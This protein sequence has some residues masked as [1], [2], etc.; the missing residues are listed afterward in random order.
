MASTQTTEEVKKR[1]ESL[2]ESIKN[3]LYSF[4]M[5]SI[6]TKIGEKYGLH[7][8]QM[9]TLNAETAQVMLGFTSNTEF[10]GV[11]AKSL[12]LDEE[13][14][15]TLVHDIDEALFSKIR[16]GMQ[17][18]SAIASAVTKEPSLVP[19]PKTPEA[20]AALVP[21]PVIDMHPADT[22]LTQKTVVS[23][24]QTTPK[25][26]VPETMSAPKPSIPKVEPPKPQDYKAD[27]YREPTN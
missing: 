26:Q 27:P 22:L 7:I 2:P 6:I 10:P 25:P 21:A 24:P 16:Q 17:Q 12:N 14:A 8:D 13:K 15:S 20:T 19:T 4:E 1:F 9:E 23:V 18:P 3:L 11:L 5:T